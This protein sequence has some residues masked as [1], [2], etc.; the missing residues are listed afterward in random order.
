MDCLQQ[1]PLDRFYIVGRNTWLKSSLLSLCSVYVFSY[2]TW[3]Y[4][5]P[6]FLYDPLIYLTCTDIL[7]GSF[8]RIIVCTK[9]TDIS[10]DC[11]VFHNDFV[12]AFLCLNIR[13]ITELLHLN[14]VPLIVSK[15][16]S[17]QLKEMLKVVLPQHVGESLGITDYLKKKKLKL[18]NDD[19]Y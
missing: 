14:F 8:N 10:Q 13:A 11:L 2:L 5:V 16:T 1:C 18:I 12:V 6:L 19:S 7:E 15:L 3:L 17:L 4:L 9:S